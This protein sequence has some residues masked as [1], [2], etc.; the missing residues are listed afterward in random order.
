MGW[1]RRRRRQ[2]LL[3]A[4]LLILLVLVAAFLVV[5]QSIRPTL[6]ALAEARA[7]ILAVQAI[8]DAVASEI[9][10]AVKYQ[11]LIAIQKDTRGRIVLMQPNTIEISRLAS[12]VTTYVQA[13]LQTLRSEQVAIPLGQV[14]GSELLAN[15]G[16]RIKVGLIP[17]GT[18][19]VDLLSEF[20]EAGI[21]QTLH[22]LFLEVSAQVQI[23]VPLV[24]SVVEVRTTMPLAQT[25]IVGEVPQQ[26]WQ[27]NV[28]GATAP[29]AP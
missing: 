5:E 12:Q 8:N 3:A 27:L 10:A 13:R 20:K 19:N 22:Q 14:L 2:R 11:D 7:K 16:P 23:V 24:F 18:V 29:A 15:L 1:R 21:N 17:I 26:Y 9:V 28:P 25:V 4:G 6:R